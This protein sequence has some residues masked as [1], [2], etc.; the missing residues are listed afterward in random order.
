M[1]TPDGISTEDWD[2]VHQLAVDLVNASDDEREARRVALLDWLDKLQRKYGPRPSVLATR[3]DY[4]DDADPER[5]MLLLEAHS[6]AESANDGTNG[7]YV[8]HSLAELYLAKQDLNNVD[9]WLTRMRSY[10]D[11]I[12][13]SGLTNEYHRMRGEYRRLTICRASSVDD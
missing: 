6:L 13:D 11:E 5:E 12:K 7:L 10:L 9:E 2:V 8:S 4:L 3:A 1:S